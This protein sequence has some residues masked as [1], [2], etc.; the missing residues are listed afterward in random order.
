M[1]Q[2]EFQY[3]GTNTI[4]QCQ[5]NQLMSEICNNFITKSNINKNEIYYFYDYKGSIEYN[6]NLTFNQMANSIDKSR[7]KMNILV[8]SQNDNINVNNN[9]IRAKNIICP[10]CHDDIKMNINNYK[11]NL[12]KCKNGHNIDD[13]KLNEFKDTQMINLMNIKCEICK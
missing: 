10:E 6:K 11:I 3:N 12:F 8:I 7:K 1:A 2:V 13:I 4:I 9:I 5:E